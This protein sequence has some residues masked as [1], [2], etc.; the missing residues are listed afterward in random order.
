MGGWV[1]LQDQVQLGVYQGRRDHTWKFQRGVT[2]TDVGK[3]GFLERTI[4]DWNE[5]PGG[6]A[7]AST[8]V[9]FRNALLQENEG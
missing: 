7:S 3:Y 6:V 4:R 5:L 9:H 1:E 2:N 8:I